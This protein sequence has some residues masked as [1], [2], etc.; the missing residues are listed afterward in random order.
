MDDEDALFQQLMRKPPVCFDEDEG[1]F[2]AIELVH[3]GPAHLTVS[4]DNEMIPYLFEVRVV[5]HEFPRLP[6][7]FSENGDENALRDPDL[8]CEHPQEDH[9]GEDLRG[10]PHFVVMDPMR[11]ENPEQGILPAAAFE[12]RVNQN[13]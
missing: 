2:Q 4:A 12:A 3:D 6:S 10:I 11:R 9:Q 5:D 13:P 7:L 8:E 1:D